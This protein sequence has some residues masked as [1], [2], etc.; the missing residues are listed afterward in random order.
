MLIWNKENAVNVTDKLKGIAEVH[1]QYDE[2]VSSRE[3]QN[4]AVEIIKEKDFELGQFLEIT[5]EP[6]VLTKCIDKLMEKYAQ[7]SRQFYDM[8]EHAQ[9]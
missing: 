6:A 1:V 5:R 4:I 7:E 2:R 8:L 3:N 9:L